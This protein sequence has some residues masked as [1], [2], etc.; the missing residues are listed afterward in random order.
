[1]I[2]ELDLQSPYNPDSTP[3]KDLPTGEVL[4]WNGTEWIVGAIKS[5]DGGIDCVD[6]AKTTLFNVLRFAPLPTIIEE[7][8]N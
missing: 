8:G 7:D 5:Q 2:L 3:R 6:M 4:A 1:M